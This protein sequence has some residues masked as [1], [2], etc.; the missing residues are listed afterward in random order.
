MSARR[1]VALLACAVALGACDRPA[2]APGARDGAVLLVGD[3]PITAEEVDLLTPAFALIEPRSSP[4]HL[5]RLALTNVVLPRA[6]AQ[7]LEPA[8]RQR[9]LE[10]A[11]AAREALVA[12]AWIGPLPEGTSGGRIGEGYFNDLTVPIWQRALE[13]EPDEWSEVFENVGAFVIAKRL[14]RRDGRLPIETW[15]KVELAIFPFLDEADANQRIEEAYDH[16]RLTIVDPSWRK[17]VPEH[18]QYRMGV[19]Q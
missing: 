17:Y 11:R 13:L 18:T 7:S 6:I 15:F 14:E 3:V 5:R 2:P 4:D 1:A 10:Q 8:E 19:H 9:A 16:L 12:G